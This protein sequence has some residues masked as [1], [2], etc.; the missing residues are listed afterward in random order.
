[1]TNGAVIVTGGCGFVG[2][3][4]IPFLVAHGQQVHIFTRTIRDS[5]RSLLKSRFGDAVE[6]HAVDLHDTNTVTPI[7]ARIKATH[8]L[9]LAWD[10]RHGVFWSSP[11]NIDWIVSSKLL[12]QA[13]IENGGKRVV[14]AGSCAEYEWGGADEKLIEGSS[15][16]MPST[17]YG[18]SK[19]ASRKSLFTIA[20]HHKIEAAWGRIFFLFGPHEGTQRL[21]SSA[22][23][24]LLNGQMFPASIGDQIRDFAHTEDVAAAFVALLY[25]DVTGDVNIA[26]GEERSIASI[27]KALGTIIGRPELIQLGA[28]QK[29]PND[30]LRIVASIER[31][32]REVRV[33]SPE[34]IQVRLAESVEWWR[35]NLKYM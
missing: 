3:Q 31:L 7:V 12:L 15:K 16:L 26:S 24:A 34:D 9:H 22:I 4:T 28:K 32:R 27:L 1:M 10:T 29:V 30:P 23:I 6:L 11:D 33:T 18:Q 5:D 19:L 8:L 25:S 21:V 35:S 14:A 17:L 13:F 20:A 2:R